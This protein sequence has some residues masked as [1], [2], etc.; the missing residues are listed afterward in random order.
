MLGRKITE[1]IPLKNADLEMLTYVMN[2]GHSKQFEYYVK[3]LDQW[4]LIS[5]HHS[6]NNFLT[7]IFDNITEKKKT[8][9]KLIDSEE[10]MSLTLEVTG[11]GIWEWRMDDTV[12][13]NRQWC[14]ILGLDEKYLTHHV[15]V[16]VDRIHPDDRAIGVP[17]CRDNGG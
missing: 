1:I 17:S 14:H 13:H 11:E 7:V 6:R 9:Q 3:R 10:T 15:D 5:I 12:K 4:L 2:T 8:E 16:Y